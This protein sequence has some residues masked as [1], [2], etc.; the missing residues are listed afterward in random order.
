M[1]AKFSLDF[2][3]LHSLGGAEV[4]VASSSAH[5]YAFCSSTSVVHMRTRFGAPG[6]DPILTKVWAVMFAA[7]F[8]GNLKTPVP[9]AGKAKLE[10]PLSRAMF[11]I[12]DRANARYLSGSVLLM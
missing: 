11:S 5:W 3:I 1:E 2:Q 6:I 4:D 9:I 10:M 7:S 12:E 8:K